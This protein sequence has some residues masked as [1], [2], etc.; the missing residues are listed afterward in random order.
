M[1]TRILQKQGGLKKAQ[2]YTRTPRGSIPGIIKSNGAKPGTA[3]LASIKEAE[4][5]GEGGT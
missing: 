5:A 1:G 4:V 3:L 2:W